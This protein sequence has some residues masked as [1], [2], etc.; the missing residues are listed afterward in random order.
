MD[1]HD[2]ES[3]TALD[4]A[5]AHKE[6]L[7][8]QHKYNC[9]GLTYWYDEERGT[10]FCL[11]EA[12][13]AECVKRMHD[14]AHGLVPHQIIEVNPSV[15]NAFL[16]RIEDPKSELM[17]EGSDI[18]VIN[19]SAYRFI[20]NVCLKDYIIMK[21]RLTEKRAFDLKNSFDK[22]IQE[23]LV[24]YK[25]SIV[26]DDDKK[27]IVSFTSAASAVMC[28]L[29]AVEHL[30]KLYDSEDKVGF[31]FSLSSGSPVEGESKLFEDTIL[32]AE[33][34]CTVANKHQVIISSDVKKAYNNEIREGLPEE[35]SAQLLS[36][37]DE[38]LIHKIIDATE[39]AWNN[40]TFDV[41]NFGKNVGLSRSQF[42]RKLSSISGL[43]PN[44]FIRDFRLEKALALIEEQKGNIAQIAFE[45][46]FNSPS[47][48]S[49]C[50]HKK[51]GIQPSLLLDR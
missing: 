45:T 4:V 47:Y 43:S 50:F 14:N 11:I 31:K 49:K 9:K 10:A 17:L 37:D 51:Y 40:P 12:P 16:G 21:T 33:R 15:V 48:F 42:Y 23:A 1:R 29:E 35:A 19:E 22:I 34:I 36:R 27:Y 28:A 44:N 13:D 7:K 41:E 39:S 8:I 26:K 5:K 24:R 32:L 6:D 25:G 46:G 2:L 20:M 38:L 18:P 3:A 30:G